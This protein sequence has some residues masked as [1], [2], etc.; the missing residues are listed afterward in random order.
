MYT[1]IDECSEG[2]HTCDTENG[3]CNNTEG[4]YLCLCNYGYSPNG[5]RNNNSSSD[6]WNNICSKLVFLTGVNL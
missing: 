1:D 3:Y 4:S 6:T 5:T 2:T